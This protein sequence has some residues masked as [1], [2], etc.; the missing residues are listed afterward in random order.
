ML[1]IDGDY[2]MALAVKM[3]RD[4]TLPIDQVRSAPELPGG[5]TDRADAGFTTCGRCGAEWQPL[6]YKHQ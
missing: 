1:V 4:L 3:N 5:Q 6:P 2:P